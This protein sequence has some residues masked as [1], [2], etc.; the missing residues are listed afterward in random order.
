MKNNDEL[1]KPI[2][3]IN[4]QTGHIDMV[5]NTKKEYVRVYAQICHFN[6]VERAIKVWCDFTNQTRKE[7]LRE[8]SLIELVN[9]F[10]TRYM[11]QISRPRRKENK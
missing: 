10:S 2:F 4:R 7:L 3:L 9:T 11:A 6:D 1:L 5:I 8:F